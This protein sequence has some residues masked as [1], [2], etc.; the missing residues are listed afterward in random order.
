[1]VG[2]RIGSNTNSGALI[3]ILPEADFAD[4][5]AAFLPRL[6]TRDPATLLTPAFVSDRS[7]G[8]IAHLAG[9]G[10]SRAWCW[11]IRQYLQLCRRVNFRR[12]SPR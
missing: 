8:K 9:L 3:W 6:A 4:W 12:D 5:F 11:Q 1:M 10:L 2:Y 7:D